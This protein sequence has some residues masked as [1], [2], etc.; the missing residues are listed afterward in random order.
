M[1]IWSGGVR[2]GVRRS[3]SGRGRERGGDSEIGPPPCF[4]NVAAPN[5]RR[6][7][8]MPRLRLSV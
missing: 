8:S 1:G 6:C 3:L 4:S 2:G 5:G 7:Y